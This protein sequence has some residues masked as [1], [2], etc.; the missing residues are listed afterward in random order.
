MPRRRRFFPPVYKAEV[1]ELIRSTGKMVGQVAREADLTETTVRA[2][3]RQADGEPGLRPADRCGE[4]T[5]PG[6]P[7]RP[8][9]R[10][11]TSGLRG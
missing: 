6:L 7:T 1:V 4:N 3:D 5:E 10:C 2:W 11:G 8:R 9:A